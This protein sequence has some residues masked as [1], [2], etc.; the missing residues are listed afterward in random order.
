VAV[1]G[2]VVIVAPGAFAV[3]DTVVI[4]APGAFAVS[5]T[6]VIVAPGAFAVSG[7]VMIVAPGAFA[8]S[9]TV[10]IVPPGVGVGAADG[11][12]EGAGDGDGPVRLRGVLFNATGLGCVRLT[13][14]VPLYEATLGRLPPCETKARSPFK[15]AEPD[16]NLFALPATSTEHANVT[17]KPEGG[18]GNE[19]VTG[20]A[21]VTGHG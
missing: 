12:P 9:D 2:T 1:S 17:L 14:M 19:T 18:P 13:F 5:G 6:V 21:T 16:P 4:V 7:T 10:V 8:V 20:T 15:L 11:D 3:S